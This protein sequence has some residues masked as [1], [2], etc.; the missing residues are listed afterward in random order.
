MAMGGCRSPWDDDD[1]MSSMSRMEHQE[2]MRYEHHRRQMEEQARFHAMAAQNAQIMQGAAY[3][4][5]FG[6]AAQ[7]APV[8]KP[9][10]KVNPLLLLLEK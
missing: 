10:A 3:A 9:K 7:A 2:R 6:Q 4:S 5:Q 8:E 1:R